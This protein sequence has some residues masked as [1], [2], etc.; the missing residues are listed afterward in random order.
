M[1]ERR[2]NSQIDSRPIRPFRPSRPSSRR[3]R[4]ALRS[5]AA[6]LFAC[7][8]GGL[9]AAPSFG[10]MLPREEAPSA[11]IVDMEPSGT[12]DAVAERGGFVVFR[13]RGPIDTRIVFPRKHRDALDCAVD[14]DRVVSSRRG[15]F[16]IK[17]GA[18]MSCVVEAGRYRYLT[19]TQTRGVIQKS[20]AQLVVRN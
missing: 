5:G 10:D 17:A 2:Q 4:R 18:E 11:T 1:I 12:K 7:L 14:G 6:V 16:L 13:N 15:Q 3:L 8:L 19:L 9:L 20:R